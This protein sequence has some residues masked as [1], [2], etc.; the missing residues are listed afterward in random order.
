MSTAS[1][2][3]H[4]HEDPWALGSRTLRILTCLQWGPWP[5]LLSGKGANMQICVSPSPPSPTVL[6]LQTLSADWRIML[7]LDLMHEAWVFLPKRYVGTKV[8]PYKKT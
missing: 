5:G 8:T 3:R 4:F 7:I 1:L 2:G 6:Q